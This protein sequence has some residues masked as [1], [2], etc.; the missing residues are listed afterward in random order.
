MIPNTS[1]YSQPVSQYIPLV[2]A[3]PVR[4]LSYR[5]GV[6]PAWAKTEVLSRR[7]GR[8]P[9]EK[10]LLQFLTWAFTLPLTWP[11]MPAK[12]VAW[13]AQILEQQAAEDQDMEKRSEEKRLSREMSQEMEE[14]DQDLEE[15]EGPSK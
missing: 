2:S 1:K 5:L 10:G 11:L 12:A 15:T 7:P 8:A 9:V 4:S 13:I 3:I 6:R 14:I